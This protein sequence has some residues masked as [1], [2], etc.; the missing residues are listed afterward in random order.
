MIIAAYTVSYSQVQNDYIQYTYDA[1]GNRIKREI[2]F[3]KSSDPVDNNSASSLIADADDPENNDV[4]TTVFSD[5]FGEQVVNI[6][7]NP[8]KGKLEINIENM[9]A[10][11]GSIYL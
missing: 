2:K 8:T 3:I 1:A 5:K 10:E 11:N 7:P 6:Y 9:T 4:K